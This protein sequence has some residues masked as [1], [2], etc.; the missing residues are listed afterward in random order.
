MFTNNYRNINLTLLD[1]PFLKGPEE[2]IF[3][4]NKLQLGKLDTRGWYS[5]KIENLNLMI[6]IFQTVS[7]IKGKT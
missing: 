5:L 6:D 2:I 4:N 7:Y 3:N 1:L